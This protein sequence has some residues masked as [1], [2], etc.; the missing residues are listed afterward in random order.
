MGIFFISFASALNFDNVKDYDS[1]TQTVTV[2]NAFNLPLI[3]SDIAYI[4]LLTPLNNP[5]IRGKDRLVAEIEINNLGDY[6][7]V[8]ND[9]KFYDLNKGN[10]QFS[11]QFTYK[12]R[13]I[14][15]QKDVNDFQQI[16]QDK[17]ILKNGTIIKECFNQ[18]IGTHK[19]NIY[20]WKE[21]INQK[22]LLNGTWYIGIFTDVLPNDK[23]EWIPTL[24]GVEVS[25][26]ATWSEGLN[27]GLVSYWKFDESSGTNAKDERNV[28]NLT[29]KGS[30]AWVVGKINNGLNL[31]RQLNQNASSLANVTQLSG[32]NYTMNVWTNVIHN[33]S[34][35]SIMGIGFQKAAQ[36]DNTSSV[37]TTKAATINNWTAFSSN[38]YLQSNMA[39]TNGS[40]GFQML[41][42]TW[43]GTIRTL[44][45]NG[46]VI[47]MGS[48]GNSLDLG[49][50]TF[51]IPSTGQV[52]MGNQIV[53]EAGLWNRSLT[54]AE[55]TQ[56]YNGGTGMTYVS[57][58]TLPP[59]VNINAPANNTNSTNTYMFFNTTIDTLEQVVT[60]VSLLINNVSYSSNTTGYNGTYT[61]NLS[62]SEGTY[63]W[64]INATNVNVSNTTEPR[65]FTL[66]SV[67]NS[68]FNFNATTYETAQESY[69]A[70]ITTNGS[71]PNNANFTYNG[72]TYSATIT[73]TASNDYNLSALIQIPLG[74]DNIN[75][76][77]FFTYHSAGI[78]YNTPT[79]QQNVSELVFTQINSSYTN[80]FLNISFQD[81]VSLI[82]INASVP[83]STF[84]YY[85]GNG[86]INKTYTYVNT[87]NMF[88][89]TFVGYPTDR[90]I[91]VLPIVQYKQGTDYPQRI[92]QPT[93]KIYNSTVYQ[94]VLYLLGSSDGIYVT[95]Q[96][97]NLADEVISAVDVNAS[98]TSDGT[99]I[100]SGTT[101]DAGLITF[102]LNPDIQQ[103]FCFQKSGYTS[104]CSTLF[105][106]Q[107]SYTV[108]LGSTTS[109]SDDFSQGISIGLS[110]TSDFLDQQTRYN[111]S[112]TISSTFWTL[113]SW[114]F[115][116][117]YS[118]GTLVGSNSST[119]NGGI[120]TL[121]NV[122]TS[123]STNIYMNY[124]YII[125][126]STSNFS[127]TWTVQSTEG[128]NYGIWR[129]FT[130][131][132]LYID[133]SDGFWGIDDFAKLSLSLLFII[134]V[135]GIVGRNY[136]VNNEAFIMTILF[137]VVFMLDVG[138][139][140]IPRI[141]I[142]NISA[143][144][145]FLTFLTFILVIIFLIRE[146]QR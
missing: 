20:E 123:N 129:F 13:E 36:A 119:N 118:N 145:N 10:Q 121:Y 106:T 1:K 84:V 116:L 91:N 43:N 18:I 41:S 48:I 132:N 66:A 77:F 28:Y 126:S 144:P 55:V 3:G 115:D 37:I 104:A 82:T 133:S 80:D 69:Y 113:T 137:G 131:L 27:V 71:V 12:Y 61:F 142:G 130:D 22:S 24:Y 63:N 50:V 39:V 70:N 8:F 90:N 44:Y 96:L 33:D 15:G 101:D 49:N 120:I 78:V 110:P 25:E 56:I 97:K 45:L 88:N 146:E 76:S 127:R 7:D 11:R 105:P 65:F 86:T 128:R 4:K 103:T 54:Q 35:E 29:L 31:S 2:S 67:F 93:I 53:D 75:R 32:T 135:V 124:S 30:P 98:K 60:N 89:Q 74:G 108:T 68:S 72:T 21:V 140:F 143:S 102:F 46:S 138:L 19:E 17:E 40:T 95:F 64:T 59:N 6:S 136:G 42:I 51:G 117:Y 58:F 141:Q 73:N 99:L 85:L 100:N 38:N 112:Y 122:N 109:S 79:R 125:S 34:G 5:V 87:T 26:W 114:R 134:F 62:L 9:M 94:Q 23:V 16:C 111:F 47:A 139:G 14:I 57:D 92:W 81:E 107:T 52:A 83:S